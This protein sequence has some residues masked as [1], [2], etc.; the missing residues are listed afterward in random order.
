MAHPV[1][2]RLIDAINK[3]DLDE[4]TACFA[5]DFE[6]VWP[7]HPARSFTGRDGVRRTWEMMFRARQ[8][9]K[10]AVAA[11]VRTGDEIWAEWE[12]VG[13]EQDGTTFHQ[14]GVIIVVVNGDV[15]AQARFYMEPVDAPLAQ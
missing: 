1:I 5:P 7:A 11:H 4:L 8:N 13:T 14:R 15:I 6:N 12:F 2:D 3:H 9:I 10:A